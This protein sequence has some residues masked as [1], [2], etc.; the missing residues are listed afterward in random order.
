MARSGRTLSSTPHSPAAGSVLDSLFV[1]T[2]VIR[3]LSLRELQ[4]RFG[5][6]NIGFLW[7]IAE[8]LLLAGVVTLLHSLSHFSAMPGFSPYTFTATGYCLFII[9]RNTFNRS[10]S[11]LREAGTL[12]YHN[13]ITPTDI[14]LAKL[15]VETLGAIAA[16][17][18]MMVIGI[19]MGLAE[20]PARPLYLFAAA[21]SIAWLTFGMSLMCAAYTYHNHLLGRLVHPFS[22]FMFPLSG[23]LITM[24]FL[25][26]W[27]RPYMAWN[28]FMSMFEMA[29][30]GQFVGAPDTYIYGSYVVAVCAG[31]TYWGLIAIRRLRSEIHVP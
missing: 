18:V 3:A 6:H 20:L 17:G 14:M 13:M 31:S 15:I 1:Q 27:S 25:P 19:F 28:P 8:P 29:R 30:Y 9:F 10:E 4:A 22:Y 5:R 7:V 12:L 24:T 23:A 26:D 16:F 21:F 2:S 11:A